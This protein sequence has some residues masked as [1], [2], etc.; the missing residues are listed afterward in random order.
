MP[1]E[2]A[3]SHKFHINDRGEAG[4]CL[5]STGVCPY[6]GVE[7]HFATDGEARAAAEERLEAQHGAVATVQKITRPRTSAFD[8][9]P[10]PANPQS[11]L[12]YNDVLPTA[13]APAAAEVF[14]DL[15]EA[16]ELAASLAMLTREQ[17]DAYSYEQ[18][19]AVILW[20]LGERVRAVEAVMEQYRGALERTATLGAV[21]VKNTPKGP[22]L[23]TSAT[24]EGYDLR[25]STSPAGHTYLDLFDQEEV[26]HVRSV[27]SVGYLTDNEHVKLWVREMREQQ[28][29]LH[30]LAY[31][32]HER[33]RRRERADSVEALQ[34]GSKA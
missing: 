3:V 30:G 22:L 26:D 28:D 4:V 19:K 23:E 10:A 7:N 33:E 1:K 12:T 9:I 31:Y 17:Q 13:W 18:R 2:F 32:A 25:S 5:A 8:A 34:R 20:S 24:I 11:K 15:D 27:P 16:R 6:G 14:I 29:N 21:K